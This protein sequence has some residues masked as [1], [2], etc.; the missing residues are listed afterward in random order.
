[1]KYV[2]WNYNFGV[3]R[4]YKSQYL[5]PEK[6]PNCGSGN[7]PTTKCDSP[8]SYTNC[9]VALMEHTCPVCHKIHWTIQQVFPNNEK[10]TK[11]LALYPKGALRSFDKLIVE[12]SPRFV[13]AYHQAEKAEI[14]GSYDLSITG[15]RN[16]LEILI[17]DYALHVL[18][19]PIET[20]NKLTLNNAISHYFSKDEGLL[21]SADVVRFIGNDSTHWDRPNDYDP[22]KEIKIVKSYFEIFLNIIHTQLMIKKPPISRKEKK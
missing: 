19:D 22:E 14:D 7:N 20:I 4:Y 12:T 5:L 13:D 3:F 21:S 10:S 9:I 8:R 2:H 6:C 18:N 17:K 1:M 15:Y 16:A 11:L